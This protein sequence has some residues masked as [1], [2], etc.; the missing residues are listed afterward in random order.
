MVWG[1]II[2]S[3]LASYIDNGLNTCKCQ[4]I[5]AEDASMSDKEI[6]TADSPR[7]SLSKILIV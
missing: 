2:Y 1:V 3:N 5:V 4:T 6:V 7:N